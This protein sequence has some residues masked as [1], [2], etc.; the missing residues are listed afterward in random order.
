MKANGEIQRMD[1]LK[2][3][4]F[5]G[6]TQIKLKRIHSDFIEWIC[7]K[8]NPTKLKVDLGDE[9]FLSLNEEDVHKVYKLPQ[10]LRRIELS[11]CAKE[12]VA[13]LKKELE[14]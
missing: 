8:F 3:V 13:G 12:D 14:V 6:M 1:G 9:K 2:A 4:G 11:T 5:F 7:Y 10:R